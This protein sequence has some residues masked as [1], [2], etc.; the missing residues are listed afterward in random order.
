MQ[1]RC[2][3]GYPRK[4]S[5]TGPP[6]L[7]Y[8]GGIDLWGAA[9][10]R[11]NESPVA[12]PWDVG[13]TP[14]RGN[15]VTVMGAPGVGKSLFGLNW[16]LGTK[17]LSVLISLDTDMPT[18]ALRAC[19]ILSG[20][21]Q[22]KILERP[23]AW[24][25]YLERQNL[26]CRM[27]DLSISVKEINDLV[28]AETEYWGQ[29]PG[30]VIVDNVSNLV[31]EMSYEQF[32]GAFIGLQKVARLRGTVVVALHHVTRSAA[33]GPLS[34]HSGSFAG[35]QESEVV[36]GLWR[37]ENPRYLDVGVLKNRNGM[38]DPSGGLYTQ[39]VLNHETF[40]MEEEDK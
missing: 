28:I 13:I 40:R 3:S 17:E 39:L 30:L 33:S 10:R 34:L 4:G 1:V 24:A 35:E 36:L 27:Y 6:A 21:P 9:L 14:L 26:R 12:V 18:Q 16:A 37:S 8:L 29:V 23:E 5:R 31:T 25:R 22:Q 38:A 32:R 20:Q 2:G 19:T 7:L 15:L 11:R